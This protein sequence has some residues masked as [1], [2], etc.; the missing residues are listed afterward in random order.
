MVLV[1][2]LMITKLKTLLVKLAIGMILDLILVENMTI[3]LLSLL[4]SAAFAKKQFN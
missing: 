1:T 4:I 2:A 3:Q